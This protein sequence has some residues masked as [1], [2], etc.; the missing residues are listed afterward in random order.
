[1]E[2][3]RRVHT[4]QNCWQVIGIFGD[5]SCSRLEH[6]I[7]CRNCDLYRAGGHELLDRPL[8]EDYRREITV[9]LQSEVEVE[10][11][12]P[13]HLVLFRIG[14]AW[15]AMAS[16]CFIRTLLCAPVI[17]IPGRSN[18]I[19]RGLVNTQGDLRLCVSLGELFKGEADQPVIDVSARVFSR[20]LEIRMEGE[21]WIFEADEVVGAIECSSRQLEPLPSNLEKSLRGLITRLFV[22]QGLRVALI[23]PSR[24]QVLL[25][26][27]LS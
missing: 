21:R 26:E 5:R 1:M 11:E 15:L 18:E 24:L 14:G 25:K 17:P 4:V 20:M 8:P 6:E 13:L 27:A 3:V 23:D 16:E 7:H 2:E 19:F 22:W 10:D 9:K 12:H